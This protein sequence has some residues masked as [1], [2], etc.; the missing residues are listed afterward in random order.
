MKSWKCVC[1]VV[2]E[3]IASGVLWLEVGAGCSC[4]VN[5][6]PAKNVPATPPLAHEHT[7]ERTRS[8]RIYICWTGSVAVG[9]SQCH[10]Q[11]F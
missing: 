10:T 3:W 8:V 5:A 1:F 4:P 11:K 6:F 2:S 7:Y 9:P